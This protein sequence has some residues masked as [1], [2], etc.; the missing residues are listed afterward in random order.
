MS[1][2]PVAPWFLTGEWKLHMVTRHGWVF[3]QLGG[4]Q[5]R[6]LLFLMQLE[7]HLAP[8]DRLV[9]KERVLGKRLLGG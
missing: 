4:H 3:S 5:R 2:M 9:V 1:P 8:G 6:L 7:P